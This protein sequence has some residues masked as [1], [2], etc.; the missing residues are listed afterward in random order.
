MNTETLLAIVASNVYVDYV[1][2]KE[3]DNIDIAIKLAKKII[4]R[5]K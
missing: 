5:T 2:I 1:G 4:E 3:D